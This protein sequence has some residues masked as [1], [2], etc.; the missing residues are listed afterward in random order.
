MVTGYP[1]QKRS[2][3]RRELVKGFILFAFIIAVVCLFRV[4]PVREFFT[5]ETLGHFL[6]ALGLWAPLVFILIHAM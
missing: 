1:E 3:P 4:T 5:P 2:I 6:E